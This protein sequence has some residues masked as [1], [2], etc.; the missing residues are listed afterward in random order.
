MIRIKNNS[1]YVICEI[2]LFFL[3]VN[4]LLAY[5]N[6]IGI[7]VIGI[8]S[9]Y[10]LSFLF[11]FS[12]EEILQEKDIGILYILGIVFPYYFQKHEYVFGEL[13]KKNSIIFNINLIYMILFFLIA[14]FY[15]WKQDRDSWRSY[16]SL[17]RIRNYSL[18][19]VIFYLF[20]GKS[21]EIR[22]FFIG[23]TILTFFYKK[24]WKKNFIT[25]EKKNI[26]FL[27]VFFLSCCLLSNSLTTDIPFQRD[28]LRDFTRSYFLFIILCLI[29]ISKQILNKIELTIAISSLFP[30]M[31]ILLEWKAKHYTL[32]KAMGSE[33]YTS[34]W[35]VRAVLISL[36]LIF[37]LFKR[38]RFI[39]LITSFLSVFTMI[40]GQGRGPFLSFLVC[41]FLMLSYFAIYY[42]KKK[43]FLLGSISIGM[44][45]FSLFFTN[46]YIMTKFRYA[47]EGKDFSTNI[48]FIIYKDA[49]KQWQ[50]K[51]I[52][53]HG[54]GSYYNVAGN[55]NQKEVYKPFI[56]H[57]HNNLLELL[58][59]IGVLGLISYIMLNIYIFI[60]LWK[61][62]RD[63]K[64]FFPILAMILMISLELSG[65][66][67]YSLMMTKS[68]LTVLMFVAFS[69]SYVKKENS[70]P[71]F[72]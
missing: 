56:P 46:N 57:A 72:L 44:L 69:L 51:K 40:L 28:I 49:I 11:I 47:V 71:L 29:P 35:A 20:R 8:F 19:L 42:N 43:H 7:L 50:L 2:S 24:E 22:D 67:D 18:Y 61:K 23:I 70:A 39:F 52:Y 68:H 37:L 66:T 31:L 62:Y 64:E 55:L 26:F 33:E 17:E 15:V 59:S 41:F 65:L 4:L 58:R 25:K 45:F 63:E 3:L 6:N 9:L 54:L 21:I 60:S 48:R 13:M 10:M 32:L 16:L 14:I 1:F 12:L 34:I 30:A 38:K 36:I 53:G 5:S 27:I